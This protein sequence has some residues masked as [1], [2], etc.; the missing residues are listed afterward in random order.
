VWLFPLYMLAINVFVLP[1]AFGGLLAFPQGV[2]AD[3]FVLTLPM[4]S[5]RRASRCSCSSAASRRPPA[6]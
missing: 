3:S 1:I 5:S 6:W 4:A 2:D